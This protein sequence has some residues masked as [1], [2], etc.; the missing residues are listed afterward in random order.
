ME[1]IMSDLVHL[2][3]NNRKWV[4]KMLTQ[5]PEFFKNLS[6]HQQPEIFWVGCS[7][8]RVP[9]NQ[10]IGLYPG[11]IFVHR[12]IANLVV[13]TDLNCLSALQYAVDVLKV[14][15]VIVCGHYG[16]GGVI[17]A[18][19]GIRIGLADNWVRNI[20]DVLEKH[21]AKISF[22]KDPEERKRVACELNVK[23]QVL[24]LCHST[25]ILDA[26]ARG[27]ELRV[28]SWIYDINDGLIRDMQITGESLEE[29]LA[30]YEKALAAMSI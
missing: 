12:N 13:H 10:I 25:I 28:H 24:N 3:E 29:V 22:V 1:A 15:H 14:K 16:C 8:S 4:D 27:Q 7:D 17:A 6:L 20:N 26:W 5:D 19:Q 21:K 9:A 23:E 18:L 30:N 11:D 2:F